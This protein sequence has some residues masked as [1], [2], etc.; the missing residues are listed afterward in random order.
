VKFE[1]S[2]GDQNSAGHEITQQTNEEK[3]STGATFNVETEN[4]RTKTR[5][6]SYPQ[7][8]ENKT[9]GRR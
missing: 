6:G 4:G 2:K 5:Y 1:P 7:L 8:G 3:R 9:Q